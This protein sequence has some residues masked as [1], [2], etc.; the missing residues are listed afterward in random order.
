VGERVKKGSRVGLEI[1]NGAPVKALVSVAG[2]SATEARSK[3]TAAG[4]RPVVKSEASTS[5]PSGR[6]I[7]TEPRAGELVAAGRTVTVLLSSGPAAVSVPNLTGETRSAA[8]SSLEGVGLTLGTVSEGESSTGT[9]GTVVSQTPAP[10]S[11]SKA[12]TKVSVTLAKKPKAVLVPIPTVVGMSEV[13]GEAKL[14]SVGLAPQVASAEATEASQQGKI[15][16][17][18]PTGG[19]RARKGSAVIIYV[20]VTGGGTA[21]GSTTTPGTTTPGS[22]TPTNPPSSSSP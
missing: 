1:S 4:F 7:G 19:G 18:S 22:T 5:V 10:G 12:G 11:A 8:A 6:V 9:P 2:D 3:L 16:R 17:Q 21:P 14:E 13:E 15:L 20:G